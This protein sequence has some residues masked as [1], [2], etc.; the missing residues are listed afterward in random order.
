MQQ[1]KTSFNLT[2]PP[3]FNWVFLHGIW[4][5]VLAKFSKDI[6]TRSLLDDGDTHKENMEI[7]SEENH[8]DRILLES[9]IQ[10]FEVSGREGH[11][12]DSCELEDSKSDFEEKLRRLLHSS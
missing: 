2:L 10:V 7:W 11:S 3:N 4:T 12:L 5:L 8:V 9:G 1:L 6:T